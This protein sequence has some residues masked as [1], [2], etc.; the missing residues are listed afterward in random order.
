MRMSPALGV[1]HRVWLAVACASLLAA[2]ALAH[3]AG[4]AGEPTKRLTAADN[5]RAKS[6]VV[7]SS[8]LLASYR[9]DTTGTALPGIP[10]C[11]GYPGDRSGIRITGSARA[12]FTNN[13]ST[14]GSTV[15]FFKSQRDL[16]T[17]WRKTVRAEYVTCFAQY[18]ATSRRTGVTAET[19]EVRP[20]EVGPTGAGRIAAFRTVTRLSA[21]GVEPFDWHHTTVFV[22]TGR[23]LSMILVGSAYH[24][25]DCYTG[26][27]T[28]AARRLRAAR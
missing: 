25:C 13:S 19:I 26:L 22:S 27:A 3:A 24:A 9:V 28:D 12:G 14:I 8:D 7:R 1:G 11:E 5:R 10:H 18:Y 6:V 15:T 21:E 2:P 16:E 17:Y 20:I 23:G 4:Q